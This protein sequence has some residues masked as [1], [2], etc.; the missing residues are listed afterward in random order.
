MFGVVGATADT[1]LV[2]GRLN[3][4]PLY[5][6]LQSS[7]SQ[8]ARAVITGKRYCIQLY[9]STQALAALYH[10]TRAAASVYFCRFY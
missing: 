9:I 2:R 3:E 7:P 4:L 6:C 5:Q 8:S 1:L 10:V